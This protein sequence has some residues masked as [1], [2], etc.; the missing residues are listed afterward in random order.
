MASRN[1][2][3][4]VWPWTASHTRL[5]ASTSSADTGRTVQPSTIFLSGGPC[6]AGRCTTAYRSGESRESTSK[7]V[8]SFRCATTICGAGRQRR[9]RHFVLHP[10]A[11]SAARRRWRQRDLS[12]EPHHRTGACSRSGPWVARATVATDPF[13]RQPV[14]GR[15]VAWPAADGQHDGECLARSRRGRCDARGDGLR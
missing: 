9:R 7:R 11:R 2:P 13:A 3:S 12:G 8:R 14:T 6:T 4:L 10:I 1:S 15:P 5:Q